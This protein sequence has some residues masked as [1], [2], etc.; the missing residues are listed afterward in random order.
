[1]TYQNVPLPALELVQ[2]PKPLR[3]AHLPVDGHAAKAKVAQHQCDAARVVARP[4][5]N[6]YVG[7]MR[8]DE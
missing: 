6:L 8:E 7:E 5:E 1:M 4:R 2:G 3:L